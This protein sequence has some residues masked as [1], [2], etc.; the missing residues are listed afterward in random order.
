MKLDVDYLIGLRHDKRMTQTEV[1][2]V[3]GFYEGCMHKLEKGHKN[4]IYYDKL[5]KLAVFFDVSPFDLVVE[6]EKDY[7]FLEVKE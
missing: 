1:D 5:L 4:Y 7:D 2:K 6:E 3:L